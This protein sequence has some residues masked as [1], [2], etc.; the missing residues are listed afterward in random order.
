MRRNVLL[1]ALLAAPMSSFAG[2]G[3]RCCIVMTTE[4]ATDRPLVSLQTG[5]EGIE[6][7]EAQTN[8]KGT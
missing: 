3:H 8:R 2:T 6:K 4:P 5:G 1:L 7:I